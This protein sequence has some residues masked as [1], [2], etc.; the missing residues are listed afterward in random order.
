MEIQ[1]NVKEQESQ[2]AAT[3][4]NIDSLTQANC[5]QSIF[6]QERFKEL[7]AQ[8][9]VLDQEIAYISKPLVEQETTDHLQINFGLDAL[10]E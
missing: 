10:L 9:N 2:K 3:Q 8:L 5:Y 6:L 1:D 7:Q 4:G